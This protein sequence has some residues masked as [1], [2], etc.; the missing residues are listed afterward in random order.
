MTTEEIYEKL[1]EEMSQPAG[2]GGKDIV[3]DLGGCGSVIDAGQGPGGEG[4]K[5]PD[6][7]QQGQGKGSEGTAQAIEREWDESL[8]TVLAAERAKHAGNMPGF[9][10]RLIAQLKRP[11]VNW[12]DATRQFIDQSLSKDY[13]Y[14]KPNRRSYSTGLMLPGT[15]PDALHELVGIID[16][17]GSISNEMAQ[18]MVSELAAALYD[19]VT[20]KLWIVYTDTD[21]EHVDEY[22]PGDVVTC[23]TRDGGGTDFRAVMK[24]VRKEAPEAA[25]AIFLTDMETGSFGED[26]G[27]PV[28]FGVY[29]THERMESIKPPFG[30][31]IMVETGV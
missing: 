25:C 23:K 10:Q 28:L 15:V 31:C 18:A 5:G 24:W 4:D 19:G 2:G 8:R 22:Y 6:G 27:I 26:P 16:I 14:A 3:I 17:S 7:D 20:D 12:R 9:M 1:P 21:V 11:K 29:N 13:S 30:S